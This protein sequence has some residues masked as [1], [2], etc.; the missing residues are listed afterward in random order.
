[1][2]SANVSAL[3]ACAEPSRPDDGT[4]PRRAAADGSS[5]FRAQVFDDPREAVAEG[6]QLLRMLPRRGG[7][8]AIR[9]AI[10]TGP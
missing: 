2:G 6:L 10:S 1:M 7:P 5:P 3:V 9:V 8:E 4:R